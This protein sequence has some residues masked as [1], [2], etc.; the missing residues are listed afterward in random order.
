LQN[1]FST[2][3]MGAVSAQTGEGMDELKAKLEKWLES[4]WRKRPVECN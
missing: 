1:R 4:A 2:V 3:E